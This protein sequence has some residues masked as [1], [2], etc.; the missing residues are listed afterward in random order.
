MS[1]PEMFLC[2]IQAL[3]QLRQHRADR[4][5]RQ[6]QRAYMAQRVLSG[7]IQQA[8]ERVEQVRGVET[9]QCN[10]LL[11]RHRGQVLSP[12]AL[13]SWDEDERK[14]SAQTTQQKAH[15]Q[16]LFDQQAR[17]NEQLEQA[18]LQSS[19]CSRQ[20]EKLRELSALLA[21]EEE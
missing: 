6:L 12:Q 14:L 7:R 15:L 4:A 16:E 19:I 13:T 8:R 5:A 3:Q 9:R 10:E 17:E 1:P 2:E 11:N 18:R 21:Q 20:V